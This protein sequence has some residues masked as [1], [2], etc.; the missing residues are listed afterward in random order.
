MRHASDETAVV[1]QI[2]DVRAVESVDEIVAVPGID[3][4]VVG[5]FDL[6]GSMGRLGQT[7][8]P[9]VVRAIER[10]AAA[11]AARGV[12]AGIFA[13]SIEQARAYLAMGYRLV[14]LGVDAMIL[15]RAAAELRSAL[16]RG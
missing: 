13:P 4:A 11:C 15:L 6:S 10:V 2:E 3:A 16:D 9:D 12:A 1:V 5:P 7:S 14:A 8:H